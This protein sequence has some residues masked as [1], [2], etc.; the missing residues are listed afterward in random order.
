[1][2]LVEELIPEIIGFQTCSINPSGSVGGGVASRT[3]SGEEGRPPTAPALSHH[4]VTR[5]FFF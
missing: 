2:R 3:G 5:V 4:G 1:M